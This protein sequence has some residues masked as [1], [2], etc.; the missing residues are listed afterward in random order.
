[1]C[2][3]R[4]NPGAAAE[5]GGRGCDSAGVRAATCPPACGGGRYPAPQRTLRRRP[6]DTA[7]PGVHTSSPLRTAD[8][9]R[10]TE[11]RLGRGKGIEGGSTSVRVSSALMRSSKRRARFLTLAMF[12]SNSAIFLAR[13][14]ED[15]VE[16]LR[17]DGGWTPAK[18]STESKLPSWA[19]PSWALP[20]W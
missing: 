17:A 5:L 13:I 11:Q 12:S 15:G 7:R 1:M 10:R 9:R 2:G 4:E 18:E 20:S 16:L 8:G 19:L 3:A 14:S 6:A